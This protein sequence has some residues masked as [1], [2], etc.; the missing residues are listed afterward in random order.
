MEANDTKITG[1]GPKREK[2]K[3]TGEIIDAMV[4]RGELQPSS[5]LQISDLF[6]NFRKQLIQVRLSSYEDQVDIIIKDVHLDDFTV[7][8]KTVLIGRGQEAERISVEN[9]TF[10][11][12]VKVDPEGE[13]FKKMFS[14]YFKTVKMTIE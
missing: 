11:M 14:V 4:F 9:V 8:T 10:K 1:F 12:S 2:N 5:S 3:E 6:G 7:K 13:L